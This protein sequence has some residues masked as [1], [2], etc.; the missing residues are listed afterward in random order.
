MVRYSAE[1]IEEKVHS[2]RMML[3]EKQEP[4]PATTERPTWV[5]HNQT[6]WIL[7]GSILKNVFL[8]IKG[9]GD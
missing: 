8:Q 4:A 6:T 3:Q 5:K 9:C 2:F 1:E 7:C